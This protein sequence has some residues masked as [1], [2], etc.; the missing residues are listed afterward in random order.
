MW[1]KIMWKYNI[2]ININ[3]N[4]NEIMKVIICVYY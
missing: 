1:K 3:N 2:N 4:E